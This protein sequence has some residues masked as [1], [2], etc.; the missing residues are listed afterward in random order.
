MPMRLSVV[1]LTLALLSISFVK[2]SA[3]A[4]AAAK[5]SPMAILSIIPA[6]GE[7]GTS[8]VLSGSGFTDKT[9]AFVGNTEVPAKLLGPRQV[10]FDV[11]NLPPGLYALFLKRGDGMTSRAYNFT[12]LPPTPVVQSLSPDTVN[13]CAANKEREVVVSGRNFQAKSQI[14][15]DGAAIKATFLSGESLSFAVP[16]LA[17]GLHQVQVRN[18]GDALSVAQGLFI[19]GRPEITTVTTGEESVNYYNLYIGGRNF[20]QDSTLVITEERELEQT[21]IQQPVYDVKR[22]RSG[23]ASATE[24]EKTV[25][26]NCGQLIYQRFPYSSTPKNFKLQVINPD[27][28]ESTVI[29]VSAP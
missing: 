21:G 10:T 11:P 23:T 14:L 5:S 17:P 3:S 24:R 7:P 1:L 19:D 26:V 29:Q 25:F 15:L 16:R 12:L 18:P 13:T 28:E 2:P 4:T 22:L 8:V 20:Q 6:Q 9:T 27:G